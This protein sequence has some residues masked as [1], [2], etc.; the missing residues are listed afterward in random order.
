MADYTIGVRLTA[1][2]KGLYGELRTAS[3]EVRRF[4]TEGAQATSS[5]S[6]GMAGTQSSVAGVGEQLRRARGEL[7]AFF[8]VRGAAELARGLGAIAD[9][10]ANVQGKLRTVTQD[11]AQLGVVSGRVFEIAQ[12]TGVALDSTATLAVRNTRVFLS[13]GMGSQA[14]QQ[15]GLQLT[16]TIQKALAVSG[17]T[18]AESASLVQQLGQA[19]QAGVL[20]G[21]EFRAVMEN[22]G[23]VVQA[24]SEHTGKSVGE[25]RKLAEQGKLTSQVVLDSLA[26][27]ADKIDAEFGRSV[28][29]TIARGWQQLQNAITRYMGEADQANGTTRSIAQLMVTLGQHIGDVATALGGIAVVAAI[30]L[31]GK[32]LGMVAAAATALRDKAAA[33]MLSRAA[34]VAETEMHAAAGAALVRATSAR[35]A[36]LQATLQT[37]GAA[38][39]DA[40]AQLAAANARIAHTRAAD[41]L[42]K[43]LGVVRNSEIELAAAERARAAAM[44]ELAAL[45]RAQAAVETQLAAA[46]SAHIAAQTRAAAADNAAAV[47]TSRLTAAKAMLASVGNSLLAAIGGWPTLVA[48]AGAAL[49]YFATR[50]TDVS[51]EVDRLSKRSAELEARVLSVRDAFLLLARGTEPPKASLLQLKEA[52]LQELNAA[53]Q[54]AEF[55]G[56]LLKSFQSNSFAVAGLRHEIQRLREAEAEVNLARIKAELSDLVRLFGNASRAAQDWRQR[57]VSDASGVARS[58]SD[59]I[60]KHNKAARELGK[61]NEQIAVINRQREIDQRAQTYAIK[62]GTE[63][64]QLLVAEITKAYAPLVAAAAAHDKATAAQKAQKTETRELTKAENEAESAASR[65]AQAQG[66]LADFTSQ[67]NGELS[68]AA[69]V[70]ATYEQRLRDIAAA[71]GKA[72]QALRDQAKAT[73]DFTGLAAAEAQIQRQVAVAIAAATAQRD[74]DAAAIAKQGDVLTEYLRTLRE[75]YAD[76]GMDDRQRAIAQAVAEATREWEKNRD[77]HIA[78]AQSLSELQGKVAASAGA[79]YDQAEAAERA[80]EEAQRYGQIVR[81]SMESA[82]DATVAW[83][84]TGFRHARDYWRSMVNL[85]KQAVVQMI[86]EWAKARLVGAFVNSGNGGVIG[87][88]AG[89]ATNAVV[90]GAGNAI[91]NAVGGSGSGVTMY[92]A[93]AVA[94]SSGGGGA[95]G[96]GTAAGTYLVRNA[97][98]QWVVANPATVGTVG[99]VGGAVAGGYYG[100]TQRGGST[101]SAGSLAAGATYGIAGWAAGTVAAGAVIGGATAGVAGAAAGAYGAMAAIPVIGWIALA[102]ALIDVF[103]GGKIFG[104]RFKPQRYTQSVGIDAQGGFAEAT[105]VESRQ[106]SLFRGRQWRERD[107]P[108]SDEAAAAALQLEDMV[109]EGRER[110]AAVLGSTVAAIVEG[111][112]QQIYDKKGKLVEEASTVLGVV[113]KETYEEFARRI[114]AENIVAQIDGALS[115]TMRGATTEA[116]QIAARWRDNA[117]ALLAGAQFLLVAAADIQQGTSL[118]GAGSTL[119]A[120]AD[121]VEELG[122]GNEDLVATYQRLVA[123]TAA[124]RDAFALAG[125][126]LRLAGADLVRFADEIAQEAGGGEAAN[127]LWTRFF[128]SFYSEGE[129]ARRRLDQ[130]RPYLTSQ[131]ASVGLGADTTM[132]QFRQA[133]ELRLPT[134]TAEQVVQ[135]LRLGDVLATVTGLIA[136][137]ADQVSAARTSYAQF[138]VSIDQQ[139]ADLAGTGFSDFQKQLSQIGGQMLAA[140][141]NANELARAAGLQGARELD[142][143][144][145]RQLAAAQ[146]AAA[147]RQLEL[148]TQDLVAQLYGSNNL[149]EQGRSVGYAL[150]DVSNG[151]D[152]VRDAVHR[153]R[154]GLLINDQLSPL[155]MQQQLQE[156]MQQLRRTGDEDVARRALEI[157]RALMASGADYRALFDQVTALVR[158]RG[159]DE[160]G[161]FGDS[162]LGVATV[163]ELTPAQ[164]AAA[165]QQIAQNIAD[166]AGFGERGFEDIAATFGLSLQQLGADLGLQGQQ[167]QDY[168]QSLQAESY[169]LEDLATVISREVDRIVAAIN[170]ERGPNDKSLLAPAPADAGVVRTPDPTFVA[171]TD[172]GSAPVVTEAA[173]RQNSDAIV[174][175]VTQMADRIELAL[176]RVATVTASSGESSEDAIKRVEAAMRDG[177]RETRLLAESINVG[178]GIR[179]AEMLR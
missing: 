135:W 44:A 175:A 72:I 153:F 14:A 101:G 26:A 27:A 150:Q 80:R 154:D 52:Q 64:Y 128:Q 146:A 49:I 124:V 112:F 70:A 58:L 126:S 131:L 151:L 171:V 9:T 53:R 123:E 57:L 134:L 176:L 160:G 115:A 170:G 6:R 111:S 91:A 169:D 55:N 92:D 62:Q 28:P 155:N 36:D 19:L 11:S 31:G 159:N 40:T 69:K 118:L 122:Q 7:Y 3:G 65:L 89:A 174:T 29:L 113:Y 143:I 157:G 109:N 117:E 4:G 86:A 132:E 61:T 16:E 93:T 106:R 149:A 8:T 152:S 156:A 51:A 177:V 120:V 33:A 102:I 13:L 20:Q 138:V 137:S 179:G 139:L 163:A 74:Q 142:L 38:R 140:V 133:F 21:D 129:L 130:M 30:A 99:A 87:I 25:L 1:D 136:Q 47:A 83:A 125:Q 96:Y 24:L 15:R 162:G 45:G 12:R 82:V 172:V 23:R 42:F 105:V 76:A 66:R 107:I 178:R 60:E 165:A 103:T 158:P 2:G 68:P 75:D 94:A 168:L 147:A 56:E 35:A 145:I 161:G 90:G 79:L 141:R 84:A 71:G 164:R 39:Q 108:V 173:A 34:L 43:A 119:T 110:A 81:S 166:L 114:L 59:E 127:Q 85:V 88:A 95:G 63:A 77:A 104:S 97:V 144:K 37:I 17:A 10:Y 48:A 148:A 98:G 41:A 46:A 100:L 78:N 116:S 32:F 67:A 121:L 22:G 167:L 18:A 54:R 5:V 73:K 50:A